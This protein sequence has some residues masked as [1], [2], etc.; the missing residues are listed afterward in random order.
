MSDDGPTDDSIDATTFQ[1][2]N[3]SGA[4]CLLEM[5]VMRF[6]LRN[7]S[8]TFTGREIKS[9]VGEVLAVKCGSRME[10]VTAPMVA[11]SFVL[12]GGVVPE[13]GGGRPREY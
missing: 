12:A 5:M 3:P 2:L 8:S 13:P 11:L 9:V 1:G 7:A 6:G 10:R 4:P